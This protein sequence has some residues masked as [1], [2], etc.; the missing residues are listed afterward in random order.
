[1]A[2]S[3]RLSESTTEAW[4]VVSS[5]RTQD[6]TWSDRDS[7]PEEDEDEMDEL[8]RQMAKLDVFVRERNTGALSASL[9]GP[10]SGLARV[11]AHVDWV[12]YDSGESFA[13]DRHKVAV[14]VSHA[15]FG[16]PHLATEH[17]C[18]CV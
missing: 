9:I 2:D 3:S 12:G 5:D 14:P 17:L 10:Y 15:S 7:M 18:A 16:K 8:E 4:D 6:E 11:S 13:S 1:M